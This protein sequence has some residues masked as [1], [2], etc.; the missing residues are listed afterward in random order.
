MAKAQKR[1]LRKSKRELERERNKLKRDEARVI[2]KIKAEAKRDPN[3]KA[4]AILAKELVNNRNTQ[5]R[6]LVSA[7]KIDS[8]GHRM[9]SAAATMKMTQAMG[10]AAKTMT[11]MNAQMDPAKFSKMMQQFSMANEKMETASEMMDDLM[12]EFDGDMEDE[13]DEITSGVLAE[14]GIEV[15]DALPAAPRGPTKTKAAVRQ[16]T[17]DKAT[18]ALLAELGI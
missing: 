6:L 9:T 7:S 10:V 16:T 17:G 1:G 12:D 11:T 3:S 8:V 2:A 15:R 14:I 4:V 18:D 5:K 13:V